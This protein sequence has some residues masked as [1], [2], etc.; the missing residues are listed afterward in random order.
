MS[1]DLA[2]KRQQ[3]TEFWAQVS[4][5]MDEL[6]TMRHMPIPDG[7]NLNQQAAKTKAQDAITVALCD[8]MTLADIKLDELGWDQTINPSGGWKDLAET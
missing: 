6:E 8:I 4:R 3:A 2:A 5:M 1:D 7:L